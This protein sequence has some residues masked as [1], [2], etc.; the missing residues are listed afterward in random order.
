MLKKAALD[1]HSNALTMALY[2]HSTGNR[3]RWTA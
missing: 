1:S 2:H 3:R